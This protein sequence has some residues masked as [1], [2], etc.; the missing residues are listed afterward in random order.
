VAAAIVITII[1]AVEGER[2]QRNCHQACYRN[3]CYALLLPRQLHTAVQN[4]GD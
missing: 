2:R 1:K 3:R 4:G